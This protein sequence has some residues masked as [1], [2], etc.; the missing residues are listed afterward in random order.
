MG[1]VCFSIRTRDETKPYLSG[2]CKG[3]G[4]MI[5]TNKMADILD[6]L[7]FNG[8]STPTEIATRIGG[9]TSTGVQRHS[10]WACPTLKMLVKEG[11]VK[12]LKGA[13]Y[14]ATNKWVE[15]CSI[16]YSGEE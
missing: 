7:T 15:R 11:F 3:I 13:R 16:L 1:A 10:S 8:I 14:K 4:I 6:D 5:I 9:K 2:R 12:R